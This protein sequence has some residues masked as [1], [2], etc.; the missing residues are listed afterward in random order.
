M[1]ENGKERRE[2]KVWFGDFVT[3]I[4]YS[5]RH[6]E[7]CLHLLRADLVQDVMGYVSVV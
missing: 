1:E 7:R 2:E 5:H 3:G 6:D 4:A